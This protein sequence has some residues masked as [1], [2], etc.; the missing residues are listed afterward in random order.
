MGDEFKNLTPDDFKKYMKTPNVIDG[1]RLFD[2]DKFNKALPFRA[3]GR[4]NLE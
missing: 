3:I 4:V 2:Y 1:R